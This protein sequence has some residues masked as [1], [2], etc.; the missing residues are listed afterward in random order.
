M[1]TVSVSFMGE[2]KER[3]KQKR[4]PLSGSSVYMFCTS[5][6][7]PV[8]IVATSVDVSNHGAGIMSFHPVNEGDEIMIHCE[9]FG[10]IPIRATVRWCLELEDGTYRI[11]IIFP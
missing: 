10:V 5:S 4:R 1:F 3:R 11:G 6:G 8:E 7:D 2:D 9:E